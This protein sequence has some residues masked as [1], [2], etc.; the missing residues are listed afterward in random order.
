MLHFGQR[1]SIYSRFIFIYL[2]LGLYIIA[3]IDGTFAR[4]IRTSSIP[5]RHR[6][7][8]ERHK[9]R[10]AAMNSAVKAASDTSKPGVFATENCTVVVA[11]IGGTATLPCV[12]RKFNNGVAHTIPACYVTIQ[13]INLQARRNGYGTKLPHMEKGLG[14]SKRDSKKP[15]NPMVGML[16]HIMAQYKLI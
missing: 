3:A 15:S 9:G 13:D 16:Y 5:F 2:M 7:S 12:V 6:R 14:I 11:Q 1:M 4:R 8:Y 10:D